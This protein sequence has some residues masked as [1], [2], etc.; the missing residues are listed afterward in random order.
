M[1]K[2]ASVASGLY[3]LALALA[4][5]ANGAAKTCA[6]SGGA[7]SKKEAVLGKKYFDKICAACHKS[8]LSGNSGPPLTGA[9]FKSYLSFTKITAPQLL[10]FIESQMP[11]NAP[12][13]LTKAQYKEILAYIFSFNGYPAGAKP[14]SVSRL[15]CLDLSLYPKQK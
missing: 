14:M 10:D 1:V 4:T 11:A 6:A 3:A 15:A 9:K 2:K 8:D 12:G 5:T 13:S 7:Y